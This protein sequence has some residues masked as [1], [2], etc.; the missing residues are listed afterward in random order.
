M[1]QSELAAAGNT[2]TSSLSYVI[3]G[4][5]SGLRADTVKNLSDYYHLPYYFLGA[6]DQLPEDN[7]ADQLRK[8]RLYRLQTQSDAA[9]FFGIS[10]RTYNKWEQG[11]MSMAPSAEKLTEWISVFR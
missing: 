2:N 8:G 3:N 10:P 4:R 5:R 1:S 6:Y 9:E 11:Q 7:V